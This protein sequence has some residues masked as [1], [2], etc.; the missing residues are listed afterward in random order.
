MHMPHYVLFA[1][2]LLLPLARNAPADVLLVDSTAEAAA[3]K[4][5]AMPT[6]GMTMPRV[7]RKFGPPR[8]KAGPVG[9]PPIARWV[10]P[11]FTVYFEHQHVIHSVLHRQSGSAQ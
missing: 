11:D 5:A 10:Y 9:S 3:A 6:R 2:L 7:E 4:G 1:V 8:E